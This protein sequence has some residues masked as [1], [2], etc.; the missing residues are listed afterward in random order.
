MRKALATLCSVATALAGCASSSQ[1]IAT[2]YVTPLQYQG[3][4]C[5]QLAAESERIQARVVQL[6]GRLDQAAAN[7]KAIMGVGLILFWPALFAL[8]G[9]KEQEAEYAR[10]KGEFEALQQALVTK[11]CPG[12]VVTTGPTEL[13]VNTGT[14]PADEVQRR[15]A[16]LRQLADKGVLSEAEFDARRA[17]LIDAAVAP[18][19]VAQADAGTPAAQGLAGLRLMIR[20]SDAITRLTTSESLLT[21]DAVSARGTVLNGGA[22]TLDPS[23]KLVSGTLPLPHLEGLGGARLRPG[24]AT[25]ATFIASGAPPTPL[26]ATVM[27][28]ETLRIGEREITVARCRVS[29]YAARGGPTTA[30][31]LSRSADGAE[32][33]GEISVE[34]QTGLTLAAAVKSAHPYYNLNRSVLPAG[35][36]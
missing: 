4:D 29:G 32:I 34:P 10:L 8:G 24:F 36:R 28:L 19:V 9:T 2:A 16:L 6:G 14:V 17:A 27:R 12:A 1:D 7:D 26:Q 15:I 23:G 22:T 35:V 31:P 33:S 25:R 13:T 5:A 3:Y 30:G 20:D 18:Q 11:K 21:I